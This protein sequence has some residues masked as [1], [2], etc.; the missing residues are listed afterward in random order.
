MN[1]RIK[2]S[3]VLCLATQKGLAV[4]K[5]LYGLRSKATF[6]ICT[7]REQSVAQC[8]E[9]AIKNE[10]LKCGYTH[11]GYPAWKKN[12]LEIVDEARAD[13]IICIGWRYL[14]SRKV[15]E[16]VDGNVVVAHDSLLPKYRG[17]APLPTAL[18]CGEKEAGV[19]FIKATEGVDE[20]PIYWQG[21]FD[22]EQD[23]DIGILIQKSLPLYVEGVRMAILGKFGTPVPQVCADATYSIWRDEEDYLIDW[24]QGSTMI[25]RTVRALRSPYL[26]AKTRC[27]DR[28]ITIHKATV[29]NDLTFAIRQPGKVWSV[30]ELGRPSVVCG[31]GILKVHE[32]TFENGSHMT[33]LKNLRMRFH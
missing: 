2:K 27:G 5:S 11:F 3:I 30:D 13:S 19:S 32:A 8:Q 16:L 10:A 28:L 25:E 22:V 1:E 33:P 20:G 7:F 15:Q 12:Q 9:E 26:G 21:R 4:V 14:V 31:D 23:D 6:I 29:E 24:Q 18:I 17:F